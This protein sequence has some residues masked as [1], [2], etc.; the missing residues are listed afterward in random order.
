MLQTWPAN[1]TSPTYAQAINCVWHY[2]HCFNRLRQGIQCSANLSLEFVRQH[3]PLTV[4]YVLVQT[5]LDR[6]KES[7]NILD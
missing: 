3:M 2:A 5:H 4:A 6:S 1:V 7:V